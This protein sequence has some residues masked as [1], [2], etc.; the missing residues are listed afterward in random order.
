[1]IERK[2]LAGVFLLLAGCRSATEIKVTVQTDVPCANVGATAFT[3]GELGAIETAPPTTESTTCTAG[4]LGTVVLVPSGA[5]NAEVGFKVVTA[6]G[7]ETLDKCGGSGAAN[8]TN[9][10]VARRE[11]RYLPHTPLEVIMNMQ[12]ACEGIL[13]DATSTCVNGVCKSAVLDP[14]QC[15]GAGCDESALSP[16]AADGGTDAT[17]DSPIDAGPGVP[18]CDLAGLQAGSPW[19]MEAYCP[20]GR[21]RSPV[22]GPSAAP[23]HKW[24]YL[25]G[26]VIAGPS[27][28]ADGTLFAAMNQNVVALDPGDGGARWTYASGGDAALY[29]TVPAIAADD[30]LRFFERTSGTY[31]LLGLDAASLGTTQTPY[32]TRGGITIVGNGTMYFPDTSGN[33]VAIKRDGS[34]TWSTS[35]AGDDFIIPAVGKDGTIFSATSA[36]S[37]VAVSP[38]GGVKWNVL[39][40]GD[41]ET[42]SAIAPDGTVRVA[43][44]VTPLGGMLYALDPST[45]ATL[46]SKNVDPD[47][48]NGIAVADDGTTYVGGASSTTAWTSAGAPAGSSAN[49]CETPVVDQS[50]DVYA[51]C[52][53]Q[54]IAFDHGLG[55]RWQVSVP[56]Y[57]GNSMSP[58]VLGQNGAIYTATSDNNNKGAI[59]AFGPP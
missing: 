5:S 38:D 14:A 51:L 50:G 30:T 20:N 28:A 43:K 18:G 52:G 36:G 48:V 53:D 7:G 57:L 21:N 6:L 40:G 56:N 2:G 55:I 11:L 24:Q 47:M 34:V 8:D 10:I 26:V 54:L 22:V 27:V 3:S 37:F 45:G 44:Q 32:D 23:V 41:Y 4:H 13:C 49:D 35:N 31:I 9:C 16:V 46:W 19:P 25:A 33:L 42:S 15:E 1:V 29:N 12:Q 58:P 17:M 59:D 39:L